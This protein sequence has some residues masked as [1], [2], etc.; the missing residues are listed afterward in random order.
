MGKNYLIQL[1][2]RMNYKT[3]LM[4][5]FFLI[6]IPILIIISIVS[7]RFLGQSAEGEIEKS[8][9]TTIERVKNKIEQVT[10]ETENLSRNIIYDS[11]V[12][13]LLSE[14]DKGEIFPSTNE[15]AYFINSFIVNRE[16]IEC[17]VLTGKDKTLFST[18]RA[19]TNVSNYDE[20]QK[21]WWY[22]FLQTDKAPFKWYPNAL[23]HDGINNEK[24][25][26]LMMTRSILS[27]EDYKTPVGRMMIYIKNSYINNIWKELQWGDTTNIWI[28]DEENQLL[29]KNDPAEDY[30][31]LLSDITTLEGVR[32]YDYNG[33]KFVVGNVEFDNSSWKFL[34]ATPFH[35]VDATL[36]II[37]LQIFLVI[38][39][40]LLIIFIIS[41]YVAG[42]MAKPI[43]RL[44]KTMD[45]YYGN[46]SSDS[47]AES[48][49]YEERKDEVG[50]IYQSYQ[51]MKERIE[52][53]IK[54]IYLK[55]LE[56][57]DAELALLET[58]INPHFLY[59]TLDS[60]NWMALANEQEEI[61][62]MITA[63]SDTFRLSLT[64]NST[65]FISLDQEIQYIE[66]YL[67]IQKFRYGNR[68]S[69]VIDVE[70]NIRQNKVL[71]FI[72]QPVVENALKHGIDS[73]ENGGSIEIKA[74][75]KD[76][77]IEITVVNDG[78][79]IDLESMKGLLIF[80]VT[81][82]EY[83]S[84]KNEGYGIQNINRRIKIVYGMAYGIR[85]EIAEGGQT[86][87]IITL[88]LSGPVS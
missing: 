78:K 3:R 77:K 12:Q 14:S 32:T 75:A 13:F 28:V 17:V 7:Y 21:K 73:L 50:D 15:V 43:V 39:I 88:P 81:D 47:D 18:E 16:Y 2:N 53:L 20:I 52:T 40:V 48:Y 84:F 70:E 26:T 24:D 85:Y 45:T 57:K 71:R 44:S 23:K 55:D 86:I 37:K 10:D 46:E 82:T 58:Q 76:G 9:M 22:K 61:S 59:N 64:K 38:G 72:I 31:G 42:T 6:A 8:L 56:K 11:D 33:E 1:Y 27:L 68:L 62:E 34:I 29:L 41:F 25:N 66:S 80:D 35:E 5:S 87:C 30:S 4:L 51:K 49:Y 19:Y 65:S 69:T 54:E 83:L 67:V 79:G 36:S 74:K 63:L 60:I